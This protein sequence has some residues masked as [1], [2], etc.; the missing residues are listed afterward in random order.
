MAF[1]ESR[2]KTGSAEK[3]WMGEVDTDSDTDTS[4]AVDL[5]I[6]IGSHL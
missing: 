3:Y 4:E 6:E 5:D 2:A 1:S